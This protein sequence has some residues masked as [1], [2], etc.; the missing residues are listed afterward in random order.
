[1]GEGAWIFSLE[2]VSEEVVSN[3]CLRVEPNPD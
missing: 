3:S 2:L 1:M